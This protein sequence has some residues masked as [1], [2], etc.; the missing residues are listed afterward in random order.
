[1][2]AN[3]QSHKSHFPLAKGNKWFYSWSYGDI[4]TIR[5]FLEVVGDTLMNDGKLYSRI[6]S[7]EKKDSIWERFIG[8]EYLREEN[9]I[10]Y[11]F[12]RGILLNYDW[13]DN[14]SS[15]ELNGIYSKVIVER[16]QILGKITLTYVLYYNQYESSSIS[17][18][19]GY[20]ELY[21]LSR[22]DWTQSSRTLIGCILNGNIYGIIITDIKNNQVRLPKEYVLTQNYPNP[23]NPVTK[24]K[25]SIPHNNQVIIKVYDVLGKEISTLVN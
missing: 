11:E 5:T 19:I 7:F 1:M 12:R 2:I 3:A 14:T 18:S 23:F 20:F 10:L 13:N 17:D 16:K 22:N 8:F 4:G 24:I 15:S 9:N 21:N 25:Y 6:D